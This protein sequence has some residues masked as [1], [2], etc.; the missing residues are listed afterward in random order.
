MMYFGKHF[1][2]FIKLFLVLY[3]FRFPVFLLFMGFRAFSKTK[4][5]QS[6]L[7]FWC[8]PINWIILDMLLK[9]IVF[10]ESKIR[11]NKSKKRGLMWNRKAKQVNVLYWTPFL[12]FSWL[13]SRYASNS[14]FITPDLLFCLLKCNG[15]LPAWRALH[16]PHKRFKVTT[17]DNRKS[18]FFNFWIFIIT[19]DFLNRRSYRVRN[20][21][22]WIMFSVYS[23]A[24]FSFIE[25]E[26]K[27]KL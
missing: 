7:I 5:Q 24:I 9:V 17:I 3:G 21:S 2:D 25:I 14:S 11:S 12:R 20:N 22:N 27:I 18:I 4:S 13:V 26:I 19:S 6:N 1:P 23:T 16:L 15:L 10:R 8:R